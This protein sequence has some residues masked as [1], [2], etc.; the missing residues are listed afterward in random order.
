MI[1]ITFNRTQRRYEWLE[2]E[3]GEILTAP[4]GAENKAQLFQAALSLLDPDLANAAVSWLNEEPYLER[5]IWKAAEIVA[6]DGVELYPTD[7]RLLA[8]VISSDG[9]G[10]YAITIEDGYTVCE[11]AHYQDGGASLDAN[12]QKTCKHIAAMRL[13]LRTRVLAY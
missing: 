6:T 13:H 12:G 10:R 3:S 7:G 9:Y 1:D 8:K 4:S 11:C 5:T 2:P